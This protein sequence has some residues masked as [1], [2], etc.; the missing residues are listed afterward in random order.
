M[1]GC[2]FSPFTGSTPAN[3][4]KP[5]SSTNQSGVP[6]A[7]ANTHSNTPAVDRNNN[8]IRRVPP[9]PKSTP[10]NKPTPPSS[11]GSQKI[12][13]K[14]KKSNATTSVE[15]TES[16]PEHK[17]AEVAKDDQLKPIQT[18]VVDPVVKEFD[19]EP[20]SYPLRTTDVKSPEELTGIKSPSPESWKVSIEK[21]GL[22]WV[23]GNTPVNFN[24][25]FNQNDNMVR[26]V[27]INGQYLFDLNIPV[28]VYSMRTTTY[29]PRIFN[30]FISY[31]NK[32]AS[33]ND[34]MYGPLSA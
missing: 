19:S 32:T 23:N 33:I 20:K 18:N 14:P 11:E 17:A 5:N 15:Q 25:K 3:V 2:G 4:R 22:N 24:E 9:K 28:R 13:I 16:K 34:D 12:W 31:L 6:A 1:C 27:P 7:A 26:P 10:T 21:G 29:L 30:H 8:S